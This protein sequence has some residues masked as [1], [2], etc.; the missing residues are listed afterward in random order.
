MLTE[1]LAELWL[2]MLELGQE[3][4]TRA[5][6]E[7]ELTPTDPLYT[8]LMLTNRSRTVNMIFILHYEL[9]H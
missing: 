3:Q 8:N 4:K 2:E 1:H 5:M 6:I 7:Y 9:I